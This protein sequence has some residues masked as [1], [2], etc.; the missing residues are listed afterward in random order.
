[1]T[2]AVAIL[3][4]GIDRGIEALIVSEEEGQRICRSGDSQHELR[5]GEG[6]DDP[7]LFGQLI[8]E[9]GTKLPLFNELIQV[10]PTKNIEITLT[11]SVIKG[12]ITFPPKLEETHVRIGHYPFP[13]EDSPPKSGA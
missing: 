11:S 7:V 12:E 5:H 3:E 8:K 4:R 10:E 9:P 13:Q 1:M 6:K 2:V